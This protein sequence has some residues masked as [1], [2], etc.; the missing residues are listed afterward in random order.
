MN[1]IVQLCKGV[2]WYKET[3]SWCLGDVLWQWIFLTLSPSV[4]VVDNGS[5][6]YVF[7]A[8][9]MSVTDKNAATF[10]IPVVVARLVSASAA[11]VEQ[12]PK[13]Q[14]TPKGLFPTKDPRIGAVLGKVRTGTVCERRAAVLSCVWR[15]TKLAVFAM[16]C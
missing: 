9:A 7:E 15:F 8:F 14:L 12:V 3:F 2:S 13:Q 4:Q 6:G 10:Q 11:V 5:N 1:E 16:Y